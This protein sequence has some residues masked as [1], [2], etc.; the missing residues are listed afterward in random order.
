MFVFPQLPEGYV[1][2]VHETDIIIAGG[3]GGWERAERCKKLSYLGIQ[4][5]DL[6]NGRLDISRVNRSP[7]LNPFLDG[8]QIRLQLNIGL[9]SK[10]LR[11]CRVAICDE[12]VHD[13]VVDITAV[14]H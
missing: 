9:D 7:D 14:L 2:V 3:K 5:I 11:R 6:L 13:Q 4:L 1:G 8:L 12:V 10:F